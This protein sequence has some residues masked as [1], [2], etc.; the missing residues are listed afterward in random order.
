MTRLT[1][2]SLGVAGFSAGPV[3]AQQ[4]SV[5]GQV[6]DKSNQQPVAGAG[7]LVVGTSLQARTGREGRYSITNVP[8]GKYEVQVR[9]IGYATATQPVTVA[10][11]QPATLD[12]ALTPAPVADTTTASSGTA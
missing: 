6:S 4:G 9:F 8:P 5:A 3:Q 10:T 12:F 11:G 2:R 1:I 7:V